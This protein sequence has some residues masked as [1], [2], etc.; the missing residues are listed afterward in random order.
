MSVLPITPEEAVEETI[1]PDVVFEVFNALILENLS[2]KSARVVQ[3]KVVKALVQKGLKENEIYKKGWLDVED[4]YRKAGW[5]VEYHKPSYRDSFD[6]F[7]VFS[8]P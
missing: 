7:F 1:I 5:G 2:D 4:A 8:K 6:E 3:D